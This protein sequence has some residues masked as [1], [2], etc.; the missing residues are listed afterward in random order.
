MYVETPDGPVVKTVVPMQGA[1]V[2]NLAGKP[3]SNTQL[4]PQLE[5]TCAAT[6]I[7]HDARR[8]LRATIKT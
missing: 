3:R 5:G 2:P 8:T 7:P 1:Q 6:K 4:S